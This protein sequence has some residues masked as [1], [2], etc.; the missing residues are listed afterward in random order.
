M[1]DLAQQVASLKD[2]LISNENIAQPHFS[3]ASKDQNPNS[4]SAVI[5]PEVDRDYVKHSLEEDK[6]DPV[7]TV[8][9]ECLMSLDISEY[10]LQMLEMQTRQE[11]NEEQSILAFEVMLFQHS[12]KK[13][14]VFVLHV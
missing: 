2:H 5:N 14:K 7:Q 9:R 4:Q 8:Q 11:E 10:E 1:D 6:N 13:T 3:K 12:F